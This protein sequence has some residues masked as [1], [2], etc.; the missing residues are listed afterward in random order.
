MPDTLNCYLGLAI[1]CFVSRSY[2]KNTPCFAPPLI[3]ETST[4]RALSHKAPSNPPL[5]RTAR[6][7]NSCRDSAHTRLRASDPSYSPFPPLRGP[8]SATTTTVRAP[9]QLCFECASDFDSYLEWSRR[10]G[11]KSVRVLER[12]ARGRAAL[13]EFVAGM[14]GFEARNVVAYRYP[15][16]GTSI[17]FR[18][19]GDVIQRL[20]GRYTF[21]PLGPAETAMTYELGVAFAFALPDAVRDQIG[22]A[23]ARTALE[24]LRRHIENRARLNQIRRRFEGG[25]G[26]RGGGGGGAP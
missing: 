10:N 2:C 23:I 18:S 12:D 5:P 4:P 14:L 21:A 13:V 6:L 11:M 20:E 16:A 22:E 15:P 8:V 24:D 17:E 25:G 19:T 3:V 9:A 1:I 7:G 26:G